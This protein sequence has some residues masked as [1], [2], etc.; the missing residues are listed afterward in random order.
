MALTR[1][2]N[3]TVKV[4]IVFAKTDGH[5]IRMT[6]QPDVSVSNLNTVAR[7][8]YKFVPT[9]IFSFLDINECETAERC[10]SNA[11]CNNTPGSYSC[12]CKPGFTG[13]ALKECVG[14]YKAN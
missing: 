10:V 7:H 6:Y 14:T 4:L 12:Q 2:V 5:S 11:I 3:L 13:N 1:T 8:C 9:S